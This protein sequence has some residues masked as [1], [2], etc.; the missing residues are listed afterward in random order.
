V[1]TGQQPVTLDQSRTL[2]IRD[3]DGIF[4]QLIEQN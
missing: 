3:P 1:T 2:L 4:I